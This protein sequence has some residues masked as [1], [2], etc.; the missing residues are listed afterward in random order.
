[1][2][3][4]FAGWSGWAFLVGPKG[5]FLE[6]SSATMEPE[7]EADHERF[8]NKH[9]GMKWG[10]FFDSGGFTVR[11]FASLMGKPNMSVRYNA[12]AIPLSKVVDFITEKIGSSGFGISPATDVYIWDFQ[13]ETTMTLEEFFNA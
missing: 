1:M 6:I 13:R 2:I 9:L 10:E 7:P 5:E 4:R 11:Y 12:E 3:L 8:M